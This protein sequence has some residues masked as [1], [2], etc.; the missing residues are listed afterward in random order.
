MVYPTSQKRDM[1][2][3]LEE[4]E[5]IKVLLAGLQWQG[6]ILQGKHLLMS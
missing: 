1:L 6:S 4:E 3:P 5:E 2:P